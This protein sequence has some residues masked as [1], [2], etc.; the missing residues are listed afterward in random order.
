MSFLTE[1]PPKRL[2]IAQAVGITA[3]AYLFG[4]FPIEL[5]IISKDQL[6]AR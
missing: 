5:P 3:S 4:W 1:Q 2:L 6:H